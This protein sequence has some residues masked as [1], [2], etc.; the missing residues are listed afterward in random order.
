MS[1]RELTAF[2]TELPAAYRRQQASRAV[3]EATQQARLG[4]LLEAARTTRRYRDLDTLHDAPI[5]QKRDVLDRFEDGLVPGAPSRAEALAFLERSKPGELLDGR[6]VVATTS[7]T[8]GEVGVFVIDDASFARLRATVFSRIFRGQLTPEGFALLA[9]RRYRMRFVVATGGHTMTSV[10][11]L[12]LPRIGRLFADVDVM[13][14]DLPLAQLR[15]QLNEAPPHLLH[16]YSTVLEV[17]AFEQRAGRLRIAPEIITAGSEPLTAAARHALQEAFPTAT[18]VETWAATEH[19]ALSVSCPL[20]HLH[21][22][23]DAAIVEPIDDDDRPTPPGQWSE[24]VLITNLL[25][26]TQ[27]LL[28]YRLDDRVRIDDAPCPC[29]SPFARIDVEGR[30]DDTIYLDDGEV[31]Q[32]H[33]PIPFEAALLGIS[34]LVQFALVHERQNRLRVSIVAEPAA[35]P[36]KVATEVARRLGRHLDDHGLETRVDFVVEH[37]DALPRHDR[38]R[39]L[40]QI[41]SMVRRPDR[42]VP[43]AARRHKEGTPVPTRRQRPGAR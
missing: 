40:R 8:T 32:A 12:R 7:G 5:L 30:T 14:I 31:L 34:G 27:P 19:V 33:T 18:I 25:N 15:Q 16:S 43:A 38:S 10:L 36:Q 17:L 39:K 26:L 3:I 22:N 9:R 41:T 37:V 6:F 2:A 35:D 20:G 1:W 28:R 11:G 4:V 23:E 24:R 13:S 29:G 42:S 21:I